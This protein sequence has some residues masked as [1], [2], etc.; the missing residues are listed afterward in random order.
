MNDHAGNAIVGVAVG[1]MFL[2]VIVLAA[3]AWWVA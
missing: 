3:L 2:I 1:L